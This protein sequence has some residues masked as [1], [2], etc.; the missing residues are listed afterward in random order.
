MSNI[1]D[2][3][4]HINT[5]DLIGSWHIT[6]RYGSICYCDRYMISSEIREDLLFE[7]LECDECGNI[8]TSIYE[9]IYIWL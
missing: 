4:I 2:E 6:K 1:K 5:R 9:R 7:T 3:V 8:I